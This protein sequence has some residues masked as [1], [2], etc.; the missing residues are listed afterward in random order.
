MFAI[1]FSAVHGIR[2]LIESRKY[3]YLKSVQNTW[4]QQHPDEA[5]PKRL[6]P[7]APRTTVQ[8]IGLVPSKLKVDDSLVNRWNE[9]RLL[10]T[11]TPVEFLLGRGLGAPVD[12]PGLRWDG[13]PTQ[14]EWWKI[15]NAYAFVLYLAGLP[16]LASLLAAILGTALLLWK[17]FLISPSAEMAAAFLVALSIAVSINIIASVFNWGAPWAGT[18]WGLIGA[19]GIRP[20]T[21]PRQ[22]DQ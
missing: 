7:R 5:L 16:A 12:Y 17:R 8:A 10:G 4:P 6:T 21:H 13:S 19:W 11:L 3:H 15:H 1:G 20:S 2:F 22:S 14:V 9:I 18:L